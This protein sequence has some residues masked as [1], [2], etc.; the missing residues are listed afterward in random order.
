LKHKNVIFIVLDGV[1][2]G[3]LPDAG[4]YGDAGTNTLGNIARAVGNLRLPNL[5]RLGLGNIAGV[6][7]V[8]RVEA[9]EGCFGRMAEQSM[10]KDSTTGHWE[11]AG[12]VTDRP[13]PL[14]PDGF[15]EEVIRGFL[16][17]TGTKGILGN[18]PASGTEIIRKLGDEHVRTGFPIVYTSADSVFQIAAHEDVIPLPQLYRICQIAREQVLVGQHAVGRVIA[19]PFIGGSGGFTR[20]A[21]R[22]DF[23][24]VPPRE[25]L[26]DLLSKQHVRTVGVGKIDDLFAGRGLVEK[27][28][29]KSNAEGI[30]ET[31]KAA[32]RTDG[33]FVMTNL[34]DFDVQYGHRQ[35][36][37]GFARELEAFDRQLPGI[38]ESLSD[39]DLLMISADH[40]NDPTDA[41]TDHSR[42][43]VPLVC[44]SRN[45]KRGGDI[46]TRSTFADAGQTVAEFFGVTGRTK[47]AGQS[48]LNL[49]TD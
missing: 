23:S 29:T 36:P 43:Y 44:W 38:Q 48:F 40:G 7:G 9:A 17:A 20:T 22:R 28:H 6:Q 47:L 32:R 12:I 46:G 2:I 49:L 26:L 8:S 5:E 18:K 16:E 35:D 30:E 42:E 13:F 31:I 39:D 11:I 37:K 25:T 19:R 15:P 14:Y 24:V 34:V 27:V 33:G 4:A 10:G 45:G 3:A 1:G 41:S 21:N